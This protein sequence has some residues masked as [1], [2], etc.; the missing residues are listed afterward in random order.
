MLPQNDERFR[1]IVDDYLERPGGDY[2]ELLRRGH[3]SAPAGVDA[4][5]WRAEI[6]R[7]ARR[8]KIKVMT[9]RRAD[10]G[11]FAGRQTRIP[12]AEEPALLRREFER[13]ERLRALAARARG[14][15]H[16]IGT[17]LRH[18]EET[19]AMCGRCDARIYTRFA[20]D[21]PVI[22]GEALSVRCVGIPEA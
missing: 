4:E 12:K 22:D 1:R 5:E 18:D 11:A 20:G 7:Q 19:I 3:V 15:G 10:G 14:L 16:E 17:W 21:E 8:D 13:S 9:T 6:R 2:A